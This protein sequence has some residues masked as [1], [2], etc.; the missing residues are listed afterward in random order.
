MYSNRAT[1]RWTSKKKN[2]C[3]ESQ[4]FVAKS[5]KNWWAE[6]REKKMWKTQQETGTVFYEAS[7]KN[8]CRW[9][10]KAT[11][12]N[13]EFLATNIT[14]TCSLCSDHAICYA[15][16][17]NSAFQMMTHHWFVHKIVMGLAVTTACTPCM[18][19]T[20]ESSW[21]VCGSV[22]SS[23]SVPSRTQYTTNIWRY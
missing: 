9:L 20:C 17:F 3:Y 4:Y 7:Q 22:G 14:M 21:K 16:I 15:C 6:G 13:T 10:L 5:G 11:K 19:F 2:C 18:W 1:E 12:A 8:L 23:P